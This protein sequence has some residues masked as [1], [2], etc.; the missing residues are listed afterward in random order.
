M[1]PQIEIK[2]NHIIENAAKMKQLCNDNDIALSVAVKVLAGHGEIV[3]RLAESGIDCIC[4]SRIMN[5][6]A[7]KDI[8]AEKW[9]IREPAFSEIEDVITYS[10]VS[11][12]SEINTIRLL[13]QE[14]KKHGKAHK[15]IL[16][17]ELGDLREGANKE[18]I[19]ALIEQ[20]LQLTHIT[21]Y[22]IGANLGC[23]GAIMPS[24]ENMQEL[25]DLAVYLENKY[26]IKLNISGGSSNAYEMLEAH[27]LPSRV[28]NLRIGEAIFL[29]QIPGVEKEIAHF[30]KNNF[31]LKAQIVEIKEKPSVPRGA[32]GVDSFGKPPEIKDKGIR[33]RALLAVGKQ[34]VSP[35][36]MFPTDNAIEILGGSSDYTIADITDSKIDYKTGDILSFTLNYAG[37]LQLMTSKYVKKEI[38]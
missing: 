17:Y 23:F 27:T 37:V 18:E 8:A 28:N 30:H 35:E 9:L 36:N 2:L 33:K 26:D 4:D 12:N 22:G 19:D 20:C 3:K 6:E 7:Y 11:V 13:N 38:N 16:M 24:A 15:I 10:D 14:A 5:L 32:S 29:G 25:T 34:D 1:Y 31:I 21:L